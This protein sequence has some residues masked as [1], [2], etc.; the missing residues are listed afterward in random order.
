MTTTT[1]T[2]PLPS[3]YLSLD[4]VRES[5][6]LTPERMAAVEAEIESR[7]SMPQDTEGRPI[8]TARLA[9]MSPWPRL[10]FARLDH[11]HHWEYMHRHLLAVVLT[12]E[13]RKLLD[14]HA[15]SAASSRRDKERFAK[16]T[17]VSAADW[18]GWVT[19]GDDYYESVDDYVDRWI[20]GMGYSL[21]TEL[22]VDDFPKYLWTAK[23]EQI[24]QATDVADV[25]ENQMEDRGWEDC[26]VD[27][28]EG[29]ADLQAALDRFVAANAAIISHRMDYSTA[30]LLDGAL[31]DKV[32]AAI[33]KECAN[34]HPSQR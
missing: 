33:A 23:P 18:K 19:D 31:R 9:D 11:E 22:T 7:I 27:D 17:K 28:L 5:Q 34:I 14:R 12:E 24:I 32:G 13:E 8:E 29:V 16:A 30:I 10:L 20:S 15:L 25:F 2:A 3:F 1:D 26:S 21:P 4:Q 6:L